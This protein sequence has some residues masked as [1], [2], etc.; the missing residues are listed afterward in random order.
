MRRRRRILLVATVDLSRATIDAILCGTSLAAGEMTEM[1]V[2]I[3]AVRQSRLEWLTNDEDRARRDASE[4]ADQVAADVPGD[5][6]GSEAGDSDPL[7]AIRDALREFA[8][9]EIVLVTPHEQEAS[10]LDAPAAARTDGTI[11]G[12]PVT[13]V[14]LP[15]P[16]VADAPIAPTS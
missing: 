8:A 6:M 4:I 7:L 11:D 3:P 10:W 15:R 13:H 14:R 16:D 12:I 5:V 1:R 2:V 9:D